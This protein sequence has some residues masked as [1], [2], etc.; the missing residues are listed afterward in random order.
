MKILNKYHKGIS[1][2]LTRYA[3]KKYKSGFTLIELLVVI[4]IISLLSSVV[5]A[6]VKTGREKAQITKTVAEMKSVQAA[7]ELYR[8]KFG[9]YPGVD[10]DYSGTL[11]NY[12]YDED[13]DGYVTSGLQSNGSGA[14]DTL[15]TTELVNNK[16]ISKV[17]HSPNYPNNCTNSG[18]PDGYILGYSL[19][20]GI[21]GGDP[22]KNNHPSKY[23]VCGNQRVNNY[24]IYFYTNS[25]KTNLPILGYYSGGVY[26]TL[27]SYLGYSGNIYCMSM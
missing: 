20:A 21:V 10:K 17:P 4:S 18:C 25:K 13:S 8:D 5:L 23:F 16:F 19:S 24:A 22:H 3:P 9:F 6:S 12:N 1:I 27:I 14:L 15:F 2:F 7:L 11:T 26:S